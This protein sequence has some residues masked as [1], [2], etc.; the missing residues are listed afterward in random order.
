MLAVFIQLLCMAPMMKEVFPHATDWDVNKNTCEIVSCCLTKELAG[1]ETQS[2]SV[3][4]DRFVSWLSQAPVVETIYTTLFSFMF[5]H[6]GIGT[7]DLR[8]RLAFTIDPESGRKSYDS[9]LVPELMQIPFHPSNYRFSS[10]LLDMGA[11]M[12]LNSF[13]PGDAKGRLF[14]LFSSRQHGESFSTFVGRIVKQG[15]ILLVLRDTGGHVFGGFSSQSWSIGPEFTGSP[16]CFLYTLYPSVG[17]YDSTGYNSNYMYL[18]Q[19][20]QTLPN[21]LG[22]GGQLNYFGLWL[23]GDYGSGHSMARPTCTTY[24]S[25]T[26]SSTEEFKID[27][28]EAWGVGDPPEPEVKDK[29]ILDKDKTAQTLLDLA[30]K[31]RHSEGLR[32]PVE[33]DEETN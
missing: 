28:L 7:V 21:G 22:M 26:L 18:E 33:S 2:G 3:S 25:P 17:V 23:S 4:V 1:K 14:P 8:Q 12:F 30:G 5:L 13:L 9:L 19:N 27:C 31:T 11:V 16:S 15:P 6:H 10:D 29:S 24:G 20:A 32:T